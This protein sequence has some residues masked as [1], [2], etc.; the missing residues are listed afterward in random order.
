MSFSNYLMPGKLI[1]I[2]EGTLFEILEKKSTDLREIS[3]KRI[4]LIRKL[5]TEDNLQEYLNTSRNLYNLINEQ[6]KF[7]ENLNE[8]LN[9]I[10]KSMRKNYNK[11]YVEEI[12]VIESRGDFKKKTTLEKIFKEIKSNFYL[13]NKDLIKKI[14]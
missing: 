8:T 10:M 11:I 4:E 3:T 13:Y 7:L 5:R 6:I 9:S 12:I 14:N 2:R 1:D